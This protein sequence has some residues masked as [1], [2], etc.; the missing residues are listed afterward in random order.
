MESSEGAQEAG[1]KGRIFKRIRRKAEEAIVGTFIKVERVEKGN[2]TMRNVAQRID[3]FLGNKAAERIVGQDRWANPFSMADIMA[4]LGYD[5]MWSGAD[6]YKEF[7]DE[8]NETRRVVDGLIQ[9][10]VLER[11]SL[12][13]PDNGGEIFYYKVVDG[14]LLKE[15]AAG[16][17]DKKPLASVA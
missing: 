2:I 8:Y 14:K 10:K 17:F 5:N 15:A 13:E 6:I 4:C 11:I 7:T 3:H 9:H 16:K 12:D 1:V